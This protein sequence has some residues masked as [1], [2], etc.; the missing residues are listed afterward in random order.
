MTKLKIEKFRMSFELSRFSRFL[1]VGTGESE[2]YWNE[3][4]YK[5]GNRWWKF[6]NNKSDFEIAT[7]EIENDET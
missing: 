5:H 7:I 2:K 3:L 1:L 4:R 6:W